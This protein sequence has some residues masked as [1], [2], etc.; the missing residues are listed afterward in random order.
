MKSILTSGLGMLTAASLAMPDMASADYP[1][2]PVK[3]IVPAAA[4]GGTDT[5]VRLMQPKLEEHLG[6]PVA[7]I[8]VP[9]GG[10]VIGNRRVKDAEPDGYS[11]LPIHVALHTTDILGKA[12]FSWQDFEVGC[13]TTSAPVTMV[14]AADSGYETLDELLDAA[15]ENPNELVAAA[16]LGAVN[17]FASILLANAHGEAQFRY[18]QVGG[19]AKTVASLLGGHSVSGVL[20]IAEALPYHESGELRV[21]TVMADERHPA[22][23]E[24]PTAE[25]LG[26]DVQFSV[27]YWWFMPE[28][29]PEDRL[30][31]FCNAVGKVM[32]DP[33]IQSTFEDRLI[34]PTFNQGDE[35]VRQIEAQY[36]MIQEAAEA[37]GM[38]QN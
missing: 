28:G 27:D 19:G 4:G 16:N 32:E 38:A 11:V 1:E 2:K 8:N 37:A 15:A 3:I 30:E 10:T 13:G 25:E 23:P 18:V 17:H 5:F 36:E 34:S 12:D 31:T 7:V 20:T 21:L 22:M 35:T 6:A 9:G 29:T 14:T 24:V 33:E 26:Y